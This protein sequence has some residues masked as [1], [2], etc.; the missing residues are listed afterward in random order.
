MAF[1]R[2]N[3]L[4]KTCYQSGSDLY[5][6]VNNNVDFALVYRLDE[7]LPDRI[8]QYKEKGYVVHI[9]TGISWGHYQ[10]YLYGEYDGVNHWDE[11][12]TDRFGNKILH[13]PDIPYIVPSIP[14]TDYLTEKFKKVID[15]DVE[16]IHVEEPEFWDRAGYSEGFKREFEMYYHKPWEAPHESVDARFKCAKLKAYL[17]SR[18]ID[19]LSSALKDYSIRKHGKAVRFYVPTHSLLNYTQ[20]KI[21]SPE[22]KLADIPG[23]DG[24]IA[25]V[26]TGTSREK[27][28]YNGV[29][30]ERTFETAFLEY[31]VMQELTNRTGRRMWFLHDP[32]ED[33]ADFDWDDYR[34]NYFKTVV[35]SLMH[36]GI[37]DYEVCPWPSR[38]FDEKYPRNTPEAQGISQEYKTILNNMFNTLG[39]IENS[40]SDMFKTGIL[41]SDSQLYQREYPD[42]LFSQAAK[43][44]V[45]TV[46]LE[47]PELW[48]EFK[49]KLFVNPGENSEL[50]L[51]YM[52]SKTFPAFY[53]LSLP[54]L[55]YGVPVCPVLL[56]NARRYPGYLDDYKVILM[57]YEY[58][59]PDY[60]DANTV[61]CNWVNNGGCLIYVGNGFD[62]YN[63][64]K[65]WWTGKYKNPAEHLL[66][67]FGI[68]EAISDT[69]INYGKGCVGYLNINP[70]E[71]S[72]NKEGSDRLRDFVSRAVSNVNIKYNYSNCLKVNRGIYTIAACLDE[73]VNSEPVV[74]NGLFADMFTQD[75]AVIDKKTLLPG[76]NVFL[77]DLDKIKE[78][79]AV[80]GTSLRIYSLDEDD[81][82]INVVAKGAKCSAKIRL[83]IGFAPSNV[84]VNGEKCDYVFDNHSGTVLISFESDG[85]EYHITLK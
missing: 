32:I 24:C 47:S 31:G 8:R 75:F 62:P 58:M 25:Q 55:K 82:K 5:D 4:E 66:E 60:P 70:V 53:S 46:L 68:D 74:I 34:T 33:C 45:G 54:L 35:A 27:N 23:V 52:A 56:D 6:N 81:K 40:Y 36:T 14:F 80:I 84:S 83:K 17:F 9:M 77:C 64:I 30:K 59:K 42:N 13:S 41:M 20:W 51:K 79:T 18:T 19:R 39:N 48:E 21:V 7:S 15:L 12:Q 2:D 26:W 69:I 29:L 67:L 10:D 78:K 73:S 3:K 63:Q 22:G 57:S 1:I 65:S 37:N 38:V 16:A 72:F 61:L 71:L 50:M 44:E 28:W 85:S 76:E 49:N 11:A 43:E